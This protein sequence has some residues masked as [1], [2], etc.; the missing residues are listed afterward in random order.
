MQLT[1]S[2]K[3]KE[4]AQEIVDQLHASPKSY[5]ELVQRSHL[6]MP[7][8]QEALE[9]VGVPDDLKYLA[10]V[11][12]WLKGDAVSKSNAVGFWQFKDFTAREVGLLINQQV[13]ERKHI[14]R[15]S[16]GAGRYLYGLNQ[17]FGNWIYAI[18][19]YNR[20][21]RGAIP[22]TDTRYYGKNKMTIPGRF[23]SICTES[24]CL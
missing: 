19:G 12:S 3:A 11:E 1:L 2:P 15:S 7:F 17:Q 10:V 20:G 18:I 22:F 23:A 24:D 16:I 6:Y 21:G 14:F 9:I 8:I 4:R 13:D 5:E